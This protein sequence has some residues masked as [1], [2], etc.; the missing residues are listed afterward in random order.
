[1]P[2]VSETVRRCRVNNQQ[3]QPLELHFDT[4]VV[5]LPPRG[6]T[7]IDTTAAAGPQF[8]L[9][10]QQRLIDVYEVDEEASPDEPAA[11]A[12]APKPEE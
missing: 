8:D 2:N 1:M 3:D 12:S 5:V 11:A 6:S 7:T 4:G 9:L 10:R